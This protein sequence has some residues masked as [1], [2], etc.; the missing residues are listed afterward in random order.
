MKIVEFWGKK[1]IP[2]PTGAF[3]GE[4]PVG[5]SLWNMRGVDFST[6][7]YLMLVNI[8]VIK[9]RI[10]EFKNVFFGQKLQC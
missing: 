1:E 8:M 5:I 10:S 6:V 2:F 4:L 3:S 7:L 9:S